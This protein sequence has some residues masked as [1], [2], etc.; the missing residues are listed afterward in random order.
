MGGEAKHAISCKATNSVFLCFHHLG[1]DTKEET[2]NTGYYGKTQG[3]VKSKKSGGFSV[4]GSS[5]YHIFLNMAHVH[6]FVRIWK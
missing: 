1:G 3:W 6:I 5:T 4:M 2:T